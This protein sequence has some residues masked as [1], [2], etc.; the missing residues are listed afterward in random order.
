MKKKNSNVAFVAIVAQ[1]ES[2]RY[3]VL[4]TSKDGGF[5][6]VKDTGISLYSQTPTDK[7]GFLAAIDKV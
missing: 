5:C 6:E 2:V 1:K 7:K 4:S 3:F